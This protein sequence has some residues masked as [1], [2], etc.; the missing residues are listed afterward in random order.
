MDHTHLSS[1]YISRSFMRQI[2]QQIAFI[3]TPSTGEW[4]NP[5]P[6]IWC[7]YSGLIPAYTAHR[8]TFSGHLSDILG[9]KMGTLGGVLRAFMNI[10]RGVLTS[11]ILHLSLGKLLEW[12]VISRT[13][14]NLRVVSSW[15]SIVHWVPV[16]SSPLANFSKRGWH[17]S[18][19]LSSHKGKQW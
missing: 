17:G 5:G 15:G 18:F 8:E 7:Y 1:P 3:A 4:N 16:Q 10:L 14:G 6:G 19:S 2:G 12:S 11:R 9:P 13:R